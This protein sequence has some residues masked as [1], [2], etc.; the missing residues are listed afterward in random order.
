M[1][2]P[3]QVFQQAIRDTLIADAD[4]TKLVDP[5]NIR[6][7]SSKPDG[8]PCIRMATPQVINHGSGSGCTRVA[9]VHIDLHVWTLDKQHAT[10]ATLPSEQGKPAALATHIGALVSDLLWT[11][12]TPPE[13]QIVDYDRPSF[14]FMR[15]P[16]PDLSYSHGVATVSAVFVWRI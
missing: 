4:L 6:A 2:D 1:F 12:P 5:Q 14:R 9:S 13:G 3:V 15:D 10:T 11:Q 7:G 16:D 8:L